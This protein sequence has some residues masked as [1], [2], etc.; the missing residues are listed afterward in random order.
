MILCLF[1]LFSGFAGDR[2]NLGEKDFHAVME[3]KICVVKLLSLL[4]EI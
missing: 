4:L 1:A 3:K 2:H